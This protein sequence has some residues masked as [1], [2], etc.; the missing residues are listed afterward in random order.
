[1]EKLAICQNGQLPKDAFFQVSQLIEEYNL[2]HPNEM[3]DKN[4]EVLQQMYEQ[5]YSI[6]AV[7]PNNPQLV[8][9]HTALYPFN[10]QSAFGLR[11]YE[12]GSWIVHP[13]YRHHRVN[14][15]TVGE[16]VASELISQIKDPIIA[17]VK[18]LN[19]LLAFERLGFNPIEFNKFPC[20]SSL[21]CTCPSSSE[22]YGFSTC[23]HR[24]QIPGKII[25]GTNPNEPAKITCTLVGYNLNQLTE[26]EKRLQQQLGLVGQ[27]LNSDF[28]Q[29]ARERFEQLGIQIL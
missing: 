7:D 23:Q 10:L 4:P 9:A 29:K 18:R 13:E 21:T 11:L 27:V 2:A 14:G 16:F 12:M 15:F 1:M 25:N 6:V 17:T 5:G 24:S 20:V 26:L 28:F 3:L 22:H 19:T 8:I